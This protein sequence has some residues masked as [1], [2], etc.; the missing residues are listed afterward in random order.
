MPPIALGAAA[1]LASG[2]NRKL[3]A[4][5]T[6]TSTSPSLTTSSGTLIITF[7]PPAYPSICVIAIKSLSLTVAVSNVINSSNGGT[8]YVNSISIH[9]SNGTLLARSVQNFSYNLPDGQT[10]VLPLTVSETELYGPF[11]TGETLQVRLP[12]YHSGINNAVIQ[13]INSTCEAMIHWMEN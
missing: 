1:L 8:I 2:G 12:Y 11:S 6:Y 10:S 13:N 9:N 3:L 4:A 5:Q 7:T